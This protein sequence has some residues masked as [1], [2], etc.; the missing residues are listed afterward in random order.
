MSKRTVQLTV[1]VTDEVASELRKVAA[2]RG[3]S[4]ALMASLV[5]GVWAFPM[6]GTDHTIAGRLEKREGGK[7]PPEP[8]PRCGCHTPPERRVAMQKSGGKVWICDREGCAGR[9]PRG[10]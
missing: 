5:L 8:C 6:D 10:S 9:K 3:I 7:L 4:P 2:A 1:R